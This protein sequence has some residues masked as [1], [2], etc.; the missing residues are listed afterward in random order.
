MKKFTLFFASLYLTT[1]VF[2]ASTGDIG[3]RGVDRHRSGSVHFMTSF[4]DSGQVMKISAADL[5][6]CDDSIA[7][8]I[9]YPR[10]L[11]VSEALGSIL[12]KLPRVSISGRKIDID[13][14]NNTICD[15]GANLI[16]ERFRSIDASTNIEEI[17][18]SW[19]RMTDGGI[20]TLVTKLK[21]LLLQPGF[22][23]L[24]IAGNY[25]ANPANIRSILS[26]FTTDEQ[27]AIVYKVH[28]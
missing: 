1:G 3:E 10:P 20:S 4:D 19:N 24:K 6:I 9:K 12:E 18:V 15:E 8:A 14:S 23:F 28:S 25:G 7:M 2:N 13:L 5:N 21:P 22:K 26:K 27:N 17:D 11:S 16:G